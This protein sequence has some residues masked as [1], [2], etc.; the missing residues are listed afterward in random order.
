MVCHIAA[1]AH[2]H[3][4]WRLCACGPGAGADQCCRRYLASQS[5]VQPLMMIT[6]LS[7]L[8]TPVYLWFF[9]LRCAD[10][11]FNS[12]IACAL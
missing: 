1:H 3:A 12:N 2:A 11:I 5:V 4:P 7:T 10:A 8:M 6:M 9:I